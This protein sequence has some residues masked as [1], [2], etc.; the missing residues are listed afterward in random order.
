MAQLIHNR[1]I[2]TNL[3]T[4]YYSTTTILGRALT[5]PYV[6]P[7][8]ILDLLVLVAQGAELVQ[9]PS[10]SIPYV[11]MGRFVERV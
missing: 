1:Q 8:T 2:L 9:V 10:R 11:R 7:P 6:H 4:I 3:L 5:G